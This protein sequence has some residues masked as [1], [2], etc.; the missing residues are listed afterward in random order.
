MHPYII[1][2]ALIRLCD[3][4]TVTQTNLSCIGAMINI[5]YHESFSVL[6]DEKLD[7]SREGEV[8]RLRNGRG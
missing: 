3:S 7:V 2:Q 6:R 8:A 4:I 5:N 1:I